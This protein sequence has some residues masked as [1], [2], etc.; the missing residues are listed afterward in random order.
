MKIELGE[1]FKTFYR[2]GT[3]VINPEGRRNILLYGFDS[4]VTTMSYAR[5]LMCVHL[6]Q[7]LPLGYE[8]DHID[9]D[10][11]NDTIENLQ[12]L[13]ADDNREKRH[14]HYIECVQ[15]RHSFNCAFCSKKFVLTDRQVKMKQKAGIINY[16]CSRNCSQEAMKARYK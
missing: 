10:K 14:R 1:P 9:N 8:V 15:V 16:Y 12:V 2:S 3:L 4:R 13:F 5:Y 11:T 6:G 7:F